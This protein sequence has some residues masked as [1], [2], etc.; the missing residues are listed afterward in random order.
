MFFIP[1]A[2]LTVCRCNV[3]VWRSTHGEG[4]GGGGP[5]LYVLVEKKKSRKVSV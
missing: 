4:V 5:T 3:C 1:Q 2:V